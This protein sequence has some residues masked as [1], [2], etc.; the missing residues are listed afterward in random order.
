ME[1]GALVPL[2]AADRHGVLPFEYQLRSR[3]ARVAAALLPALRSMVES[4]RGGLPWGCKLAIRP[5]SNTSSAAG[6]C[7][8]LVVRLALSGRACAGAL[9]IAW[10]LGGDGVTVLS[11]D[12]GGCWDP[13]EQ[14]ME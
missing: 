2:E 6:R 10:L 12:V 7:G 11:R 13:A 4:Q 9:R 8:P 1:C 5:A 14:A 3:P